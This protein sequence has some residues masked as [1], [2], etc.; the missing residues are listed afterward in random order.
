MT[1]KNETSRTT[2][3]CAIQN[4]KPSF[5][6]PPIAG[7][8]SGC[9]NCG[10]TEDVLPMRIRLYNGFGGWSITKN[11]EYYFSEDVDKE[12]DEAKTLSYIERRAKLEPECDWRAHLDLPLRSAVYQKHGKSK[13]VL[14]ERGQGFA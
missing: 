6:L 11:G 3:Q 5:L 14:V 8:V 1:K 13:W 4:V 2:A 10:Y 12:F 9:L 7:G